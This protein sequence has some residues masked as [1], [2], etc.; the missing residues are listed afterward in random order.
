MVE[1]KIETQKPEEFFDLEI[2]LSETD[3]QKIKGILERASNLNG[4]FRSRSIKQTFLERL[5][6]EVWLLGGEELPSEDEVLQKIARVYEIDP[7]L[8]WGIYK[9][10]ARAYEEMPPSR[11]E[12]RYMRVGRGIE[13]FPTSKRLR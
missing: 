1:Q 2:Q 6:R 11:K 5:E 7:I 9:N 10:L 12:V 3:Y 4:D 13:E 8:V